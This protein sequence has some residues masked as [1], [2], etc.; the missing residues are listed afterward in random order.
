MLLEFQNVERQ[1]N[2][3]HCPYPRLF[4]PPLLLDRQEY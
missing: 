4:H 3:T 1:E 2:H